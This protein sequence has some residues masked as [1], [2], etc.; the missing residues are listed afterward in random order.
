ML[1]LHSETNRIKTMTKEEKELLL[2]LLKKADEDGLLNVY[3]EEE[4]YYEVVWVYLDSELC[5]KIKK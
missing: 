2:Q 5:I 4:H 1:R 3:D